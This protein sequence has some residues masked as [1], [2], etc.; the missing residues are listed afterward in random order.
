METKIRID[1]I[2]LSRELICVHL[3]TES[4]TKTLHTRFLRSMAERRINVSFLSY[5]AM[6]QGSR[7][8]FCIAREDS[9]RMNRLLAQDP[10]LK[11][12]VKCQSAAGS[13][14]LFPHRF[15]LT[16]LGCL[17]H[18]FGKYDLPLYGMTASLSVLTLVTDFCLLERAVE[19]MEPYI[20]LPP[21][22]APF[23]S[24]LRMQSI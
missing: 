2:K 11:N 13:V 18:V 21:N 8:S 12:A 24:Q 17:I 15:S 16:F 20:S 19:L 3:S 23:G 6:G 5:S 4:E 10:E 7:G 14:S 9:D 22:H 1:G